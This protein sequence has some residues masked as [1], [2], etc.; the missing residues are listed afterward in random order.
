MVMRTPH[1]H[2][3]LPTAQAELRAA[4]Q[5]PFADAVPIPPVL[6]HN[7]AFAEHERRQIFSREWI[8]VGRRDELSGH[9]RYLTFEVVGTALFVIAQRD[10]SIK[11]F[12]NA[13]AHRHA[14][15]LADDKG[16]KTR[17][18]CPYHAWTYDCDGSLIKAPHMEMAPDFAPEKHPLR[19][20]CC[21]VW[22]GFLFVNLAPTP[23]TSPG[24]TLAPLRDAVVGR[25]DMSCYQT[26]H[27]ETLHWNANW[28]NL[29]ENFI[30]SYH[31]PT[32]HRKTFALHAKPI[33]DY[34]CG[35]D[36][37]QYAYHLV[38]QPAAEGPGSA[39][40]LNQRLAGTWRRTMV[41][42]CV[43]P[44]LLVTL[45]PDYLWYVSVLPRET[46]QFAATWG[47]AVPP[48]VINDH[49][50]YGLDAW[51]TEYKQ[52]MG[53]AN[54]EDKPLVEALQ[55]GTASE[56]L[57]AGCLH[58]IEKNVWQFTRYLARMCC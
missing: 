22:E 4:A 13:C 38:P 15:L 51:L 18:V 41:D 12:V 44:S 54:N 56:H 16:H 46:G 2:V 53:I 23:A 32:V 7:E 48:E 34:V 25:Y 42:F 37:D 1:T 36:A 19:E 5:R 57:P 11:A 9:G 24:D 28:K 20:V 29:V 31:V 52:Y 21:A 58:P 14:R 50:G 10:G 55:R 27:R 45:M 3:P 43:F 40:P 30:E 47:I 33:A 6:H 8:C 49:R 39:H 35:E 17:I 26:V